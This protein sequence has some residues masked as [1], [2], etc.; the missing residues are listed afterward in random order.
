[1]LFSCILDK[2][3]WTRAYCMLKYSWVWIYFTRLSEI[4]NLVFAT[5]LLLYDCNFRKPSLTIWESFFWISLASHILLGPYFCIKKWD[6]FSISC[7]SRKVFPIILSNSDKSYI[8]KLVE[9][10]MVLI[11]CSPNS[12]FSGYKEVKSKDLSFILLAITE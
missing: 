2:Y 7:K 6:V 12:S 1:M 3:S 8:G 11:I 4:V 9:G 10:A 5:P